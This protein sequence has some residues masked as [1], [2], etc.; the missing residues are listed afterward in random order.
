VEHRLFIAVYRLSAMVSM[1]SMSGWALWP[2]Y[3]EQLGLEIP[4]SMPSMSGWAL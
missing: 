2:Q 1:P 4:V 3:C